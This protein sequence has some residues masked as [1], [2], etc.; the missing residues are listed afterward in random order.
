MRQWRDE[1]V[2]QQGNRCWW[3]E[4]VM[5]PPERDEHESATADHVVSLADGGA[6]ERANVVAACKWCNGTRQRQSPPTRPS[7]R[8]GLYAAAGDD[9][10]RSPFEV[11]AQRGAQR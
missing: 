4:C 7:Q 1:A 5:T 9:T 10:P 6:H 2:P 8:G 11:L 3:C